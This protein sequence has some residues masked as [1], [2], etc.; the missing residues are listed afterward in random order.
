MKINKK[1]L[2]KLQKQK[3]EQKEKR[4]LFPRPTIFVPKKYK[5]PKHKRNWEEEE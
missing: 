5:L 4:E 3:K 1:L 2:K